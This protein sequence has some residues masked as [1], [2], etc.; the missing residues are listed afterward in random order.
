MWI[1]ASWTYAMLLD[2]QMY[3]NQIDYPI[4]RP[5]PSKI[6]DLVFLIDQSFYTD[7]GLNDVSFIQQL[8]TGYVVQ[9][10]IISD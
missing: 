4:S 9:G 7:N 1:D 2:Y 6:V 8:L 10:K 5:L 3:I